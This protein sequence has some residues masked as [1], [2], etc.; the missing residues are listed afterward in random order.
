[1]SRQSSVLGRQS[2][3]ESRE[4]VESRGGRVDRPQTSNLKPQT[5]NFKPRLRHGQAMVEFVVAI[6]AVVIV[7]TG[8]LQFLDIAGVKGKIINEIRGETGKQALS[9]SNLSDRPEYIREWREGNDEMRHTADD[10][11]ALGSIAVTLGNDVIEHSVRTPADWALLDG[12]VNTGVA[13]LRGGLSASALGF[14]HERQ[15]EEID[16]LPAMR[17]WFVGKDT[18]TVGQDLWMPKLSLDGFEK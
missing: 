14:V 13:E 18:I 16:L 12:A 1:M 11:K 7:A 9:T 6:L 2:R 15:R 5:S 10:D 4:V 3:G 8:F 17:D